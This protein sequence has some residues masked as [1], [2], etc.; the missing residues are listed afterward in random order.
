LSRVTSPEQL[1]RIELASPQIRGEDA[2]LWR[3]FI[4]RDVPNYK[5][6]N[7]VPKNPLKWYEVYMR[8]KKEYMKEI[9]RDKEILREAMLGIKK[10]K[11]THVSKVVDAKYLPKVPRDPRMLANNAGVPIEGRKRALTKPGSSSLSFAGGSKTKMK[12]PASVL[13]RARRE[14]KEISSRNKLGKPT[15][16]SRVAPSQVIRAPKSMVDDYR[17]AAKPQ[18]RIF[19]TRKK[20]ESMSNLQGPATGPSLEERE[21]KLRAL[22]MSSRVTLVGSDSEGDSENDL[23]DLF[24]EKKAASISPLPKKT[25]SKQETQHTPDPASARRPQASR[26][27]ARPTAP[28][29]QASPEPKPSDL[30]SSIISKPRPEQTRQEQGSPQSKLSPSR[31]STATATQAASSPLRR[32][33]PKPPLI[34]KRKPAADIFNRGGGAKRPH[35]R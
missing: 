30:I 14:A 32:P 6:K 26:P 9:E 20:P 34:T 8:Y 17:K 23:D 11:E 1:H 31:P 28:P 24:G 25:Y 29:T 2:E 16:S 15:H 12:D 21:K 7:Y 19:A 5:L 33:S 18:L 13:T 4:Q 22:T 3:A 27:L 35:V 10:E